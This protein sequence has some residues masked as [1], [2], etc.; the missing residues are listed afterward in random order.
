MSYD[1]LTF[2]AVVITV[3]I[4]VV[5][6]LVSRSNANNERKMRLLAKHLTML[7]SNEEALQLCKEIHEKYPDLCVGLDYTFS[8]SKDGVKID[9]WKSHLPKP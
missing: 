7:E 5:I 4:T 2:S 9:Q 8:E 6:I 1:A 3:V